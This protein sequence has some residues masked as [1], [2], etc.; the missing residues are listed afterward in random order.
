[1]IKQNENQSSADESVPHVEMPTTV[2]PVPESLIQILWRN[3]LIVLVSMLAVLAGVLIY[4]IKATP[5]YTS[6]SKIYVEQSGPKIINEMEEGVMTRSKNYLYNQAELLKSTPILSAVLNEPDIRQMKTFADVRN[7]INYLKKTLDVTVGK[8]NDIISISFDSPWSFEAAKIVNAVVDSYVTYHS[9]RKRSTSE[10]VLKILQNEKTKRNKELSEKLEAM[11]N[12]KKDNMAL[13]FE[14]RQG[15]II[16]Q[17]LERL[18]AVLTEAQ[19]ETIDSKSAYESVKEMVSEPTRLKQYV[20]AQ[21]TEIRYNSTGS[22][23]AKL[24]SKLDELQIRRADRLRQVTSGHPAVEALESEIAQIKTQI[25]EMD[26]AFAQARLAVVEQQYQTAKQKEEQIA[27]NFE[28]QRQQ[29]LDLNEQLAQ[30]TILESDWE[31]TK[32]L[33]DILDDRIKELNITEDVG[34]LNISIL[35]A[36]EAS[37]KPSKPEKYKFMAIAV[38]IG[39]M[40]GCGLA[41]LYDLMDQRMRSAEEVKALLSMPIL[42]VVPSMLKEQSIVARGQ[43]V[44]I[45]PNSRVS[46]VYRTIRTAIF[47]GVPNGKAKTILVTSPG[48][49]EGKT[50]LVSNLAIAMAQAGQKTLILDADFRNPT[51]Y[52]IFELNGNKGL[53]SLLSKNS[54]LEETIRPTGIKSLELLPCRTQL[55]NSSEILNSKSFTKLLRNLSNKYDRIVIDSPPVV[56]VTDAQILA[57]ICDVTLLVLRAEQS[58]RKMSQQ[59]RDGLLSVG[60][61]LLGVVVNDEVLGKGGL[62]GRYGKEKTWQLNNVK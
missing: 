52:R 23:R 43:K 61:H 47:F 36:A 13:A 50:T 51:Q 57:A 4:L 20:E 29:T 59:A 34:A 39:L 28:E 46:E 62:Y 12:F 33:C 45:D 55:V 30:Y 37:V 14:S 10:E 7:H 32:K 1:M 27:K 8:K 15:N 53:V 48:A 35:E 41:L 60:A 54:T 44:H 21:L 58:T 6:T 40:L 22:E 31:Q 18:S 17:R 38:L 9:T 19:L 16:L 2:A 24:K 3:R 49:A 42:G 25:A 11:M 5:I 26:T 56:P